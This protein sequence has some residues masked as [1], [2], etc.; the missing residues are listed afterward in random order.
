[1]HYAATTEFQIGYLADEIDCAN[2]I[3][4]FALRLDVATLLH[5]K[6][7]PHADERAHLVGEKTTGQSGSS[8]VRQF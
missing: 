5:R 6:S 7:K 8:E 1:M 2:K 3:P 4:Q